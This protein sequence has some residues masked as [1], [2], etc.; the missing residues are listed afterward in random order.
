MGG[1]HGQMRRCGAGSCIARGDLQNEDPFV[2]CILKVG[3]RISPLGQGV[4]QDFRRQLCHGAKQ[5]ECFSKDSLKAEFGLGFTQSWHVLTY[6]HLYHVI[7]I[8]VFIFIFI[9]IFICIFICMYVYVDT[10]VT[11]LI[12]THTHTYMYI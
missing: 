6:I 4:L 12:R 11:V 9:F 1:K 7:H 10:L 3:T 2:R 5:F 8:F